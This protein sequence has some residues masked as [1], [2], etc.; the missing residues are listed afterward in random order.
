MA[1]RNVDT[2]VFDDASEPIRIWRIDA[3][4]FAV[5][6]TSTTVQ[7]ELDSDEDIISLHD[8]VKKHLD[9]ID[10]V[11]DG[12]TTEPIDDD[13][14]VIIEPTASKLNSMCLHPGLYRN[15]RA[16]SMDGFASSLGVNGNWQ[17]KVEQIIGSQVVC[18]GEG[19]FF[20]VLIAP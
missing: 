1:D 10:E 11:K 15:C 6:S 3:D 20:S 12:W 7:E 13:H 8:H 18:L 9:Y 4:R 5:E 16:L 19:W 2:L 17:A 14:V